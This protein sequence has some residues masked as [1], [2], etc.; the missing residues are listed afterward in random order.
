MVAG[1]STGCLSSLRSSAKFF[2]C[3]YDRFCLLDFVTMFVSEVFGFLLKCA[4]NGAILVILFGMSLIH[5]FMFATIV[6]MSSDDHSGSFFITPSFCFIVWISLSTIP[7]ALWSPSGA[8]ISFMLLSL[9]YTL[10]SL[11]LNACAWLHLI[12]RGI[13]WNLQ[14]S[15]RYSNAVDASQ[16]YIPVTWGISNIY[17]LILGYSSYLCDF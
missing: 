10:K 12:E 4:Y 15:S 9:Q 2:N 3:L 7:V 14:F 5:G 8:I 13:P 16:F 11:D 1:V 6:D 17:Q